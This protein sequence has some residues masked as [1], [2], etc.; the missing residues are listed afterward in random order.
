MDRF[1]FIT[2]TQ[3]SHPYFDEGRCIDCGA[4]HSPLLTQ[5]IWANFEPINIDT[6]NNNN[7]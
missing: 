2:S 5:S 6:V 4:T 3:C 1:P 7:A